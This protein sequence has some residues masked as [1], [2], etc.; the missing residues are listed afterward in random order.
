MSGGVERTT[1]R[2][3]GR[4]AAERVADAVAASLSPATRR[5]YRS[6]WAQWAGWADAEGVPAAPADPAHVAAWI[7]DR[8]QAGRSVATLRAGAAAVSAHHRAAGLADPCAAEIVRKTLAGLARTAARGGRTARQAAPLDAQ[9]I[10]AIEAAAPDTHAGRVDCAI[11]RLL[12]EGGLRRSEAAALQWRDV[13][14]EA[15]GSGR[16]TV[17]VAKADQEGAGAVVA[18]T[19]AAMGRLDAIRPDDADPTAP[20]LG[21][22]ERTVARRIRAAGERAGIEGLSGHSG[23]VGMAQRMVANGADVAVVMRQGRWT[24]A[25]M[26]AR[27]TRRIA[28]G[29]ALDFL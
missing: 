23:R 20:M 10:D 6:Q 4:A 21:V 12:G 8:A 25:G 28:A 19:A 7:A 11:A 5:A 24:S 15:D 2:G 26:V 18:V 16:V 14:R 9:A 29:S 22:G 13:E 3:L 17:R 27:Y 1:G